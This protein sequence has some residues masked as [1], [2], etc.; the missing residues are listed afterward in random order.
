MP[1]GP[2]T[3][4]GLR[5]GVLGDVVA[6]LDGDPVGLGGRQRRAVL[7]LLLVARGESVALE[8]LA[9][10]TWRGAPPPGALGTL[11]AYVS[12]LRGALQPDR[13]ARAAGSVIRS[14]RVGY[15]LDL[16]ADAVDAWHFEAL[17]GAALAA[18]DP[19][20]RAGVLREALGLWRGAAYGDYADEPWAQAEAARLGE[21][22]DLA[23]DE[24][25]AARLEQ[26]ESASLVPEL[27]ALVAATPLRE[28][29]WRLLVLA[30]YRAHRQGDALATLRR[31][32]TVLADELGVDPGPALL[33]LEEEVLSQ[34]PTLLGQAPAAR[35]GT[36]TAPPSSPGP[37][38]EPATRRPTHPGQHD[39]VDRDG[40]LDELRHALADAA[41]GLG[42]CVVV[43]G[44]AGIGKTRLLAE[45]R[46]LAADG[47]ARV[48]FARGSKLEREYGFGAVRQ[49]FEDVVAADP[50]V[51]D[52]AA[53]AA[54]P[55]F[56]RAGDPTGDH[57]AA[58][59]HALYRLV[60]DLAA[61]G[62]V[63]VAVDDVQ[64]CDAASLRFLV[65]LA[66]RLEGLPVL[67]AATLRTG[68]PHD[69]AEL[70][71]HLLHDPA[72]ERVLPGPLSRGGV[73]DLVA[74]RLGEPD[75]AFVEACHATT[76]GNPLLLRQLLRA[77]Q[78][79]KVSPDAAHADV[80]TRIGSRAVSSLVLMRLGL[81]AAPAA[82]VA[83]AVAVLGRDAELPVVA[84]LAGTEDGEAADAV[85]AL[86]RAEI[87]RDDYPLGFVH[88][89]VADAVYRDLAPGHR[90]MRHA[91]A[92]RVLAEAGAPLESVAAQLLQAP[93]GGD[94]W[95]VA[96]LRA[97]A[98]RARERAAP[99]AA[100]TLLRRAL[101][102]PPAADVR[103]AV[104]LELGQ[105]EAIS[106]APSSIEHLRGAYDALDDPRATV[107]LALTLGR[108]LVFVGEPGSATAFAHEAGRRLPPD[109]P[110]ALDDRQALLAT[111]RIAGYLH[112]VD[113][114]RW[115]TT[116]P[117]IV[118]TGRGARMLAV[119]L[120]WEQVIDGRDRERALELVRFG[121]ADGSLL[122][123]DTGLLWV[124]AGQVLDLCDGDAAPLWSAGLRQA[125]QRGDLFTRLGMQ[126]WRGWMLSRRGD[127]REAHHVLTAG[128][129]MS[130]AWASQGI[131]SG[132]GEAFLLD[133]LTEIGD[134]GAARA[135]LER[136]RHSHRVSEG[137]QRFGD[138]ESRLLL[139]EHRFEESLR[140][141]DE[142]RH[143]MGGF[144]NP[145]WRSWRTLRGGALAGLG[146][147]DEARALFDDEVER[148]RRWG[149]PRTVAQALRKRGTLETR[150]GGPGA[151]DDL[152]EALALIESGLSRGPGSTARVERARCLVALAGVS[153]PGDAEPMLREAALLAGVS[154]ADGVHRAAAW[155]LTDLGLAAPLR[156]EPA[157]TLSTT[158]R[159][160]V[161]RYLAG[162]PEREIA[163]GLG[164]TPRSV[165]A[166]LDSIRGRLGA[167]T[168]DELRAALAAGDRTPV[169]TG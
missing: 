139:L 94:A 154:G 126:L 100:V 133:V 145:A 83:A 37:A 115:R 162:T 152:R 167:V 151:V 157:T 122:E 99:E 163:D 65:Y 168:P 141:L 116:P 110:D 47:G 35:A 118:G 125:D 32:R 51:L 77:L 137:A 96:S 67:I 120:A 169:T 61:G 48:L 28:K 12:K 38:A 158:E 76:S 146:R 52:G 5:I 31:A 2:A 91:R 70:L 50:A 8:Q 4:D 60:V 58:V 95:A 18:P 149:A 121:T 97:A 90:Q 42:R 159:G 166:V 82:E 86:A 68:E 127:L 29:R 34:A 89:L 36:R 21:L 69:E 165:R 45:T 108:I 98:T 124:I 88:P 9:D 150:L 164:L 114:A 66:T 134:L 53:A 49:L 135:F 103:P 73:A 106:D 46:R 87:L 62:P 153:T 112:D 136:V 23:R 155:A 138:A 11:H 43:E 140:C 109:D 27:E 10:R 1:S 16:A 111:E 56:G 148:A 142:S 63:V 7:A 144:D 102:E 25:A 129:E 132:Y 143:V 104:L 6:T 105:A 78:S 17:V 130:Y 72:T 30:Q 40:E 44:P 39:L 92:A 107:D 3:S 84:A 147:L 59:T 80:V 20:V 123:A 156:P 160:V 79:E 64:W 33:A 93:P 55:L 24:L 75:E 26:G 74:G 128:H 54:A 85:A 57:A 81:L 19:G 71:D 131:A 14:S 101:R 22:R 113:P 41:A 15:A 13:A 119:T 161:D 117:E